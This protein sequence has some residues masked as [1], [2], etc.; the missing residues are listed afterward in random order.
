MAD[1]EADEGMTH[2]ALIELLES[3]LPYIEYARSH[4]LP[5][6]A[7]YLELLYGIIWPKP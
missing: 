1:G 5:N 4:D 3:L 7:Y 6:A 2:E